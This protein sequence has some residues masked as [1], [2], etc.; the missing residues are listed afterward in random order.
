MTTRSRGHLVQRQVQFEPVPASARL[1]R[2]MVREVLD[3]AGLPEL[4]DSATLCV[5]EL[6]TNAILHARTPIQVV[7]VA[8]EDS[9]YVGV[10]D[11]SAQL[12]ARR[13]F[14]PLAT[15]GRGLEMVRLVAARYGTKTHDDGT[16]TV[17]FEL[18]QGDGAGLAGDH[19]QADQVPR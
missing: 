17:W 2:S 6:V 5:S 3:D 12:P 7:V 18:G 15:T 4:D 1:A 10:S 16:K 9:V 8:T 11:R 19:A 14:G 13:D